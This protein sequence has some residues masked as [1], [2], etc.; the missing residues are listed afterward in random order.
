MRPLILA[1]AIAAFGF[2]TTEASAVT[3]IQTTQD[4][5]KKHCEGKTKCMRDC[6]STYCNYICDDPKKQCTATVYIKKPPPPRRP[7]PPI[8]GSS[9]R[10]Q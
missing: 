8:S 1:A 6:G 9:G 5:V 7:R 4:D 10:I 3:V 2:L